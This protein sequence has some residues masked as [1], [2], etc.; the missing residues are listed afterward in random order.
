MNVDNA[1]HDGQAQA[2]T[3]R[4]GAERSVEAVENAA[5]FF[6]G[7]ARAVVADTQYREAVFGGGS[8]FNASALGRIADGVVREVGYHQS[9][10]I[11][12][13][14]EHCRPGIFRNFNVLLGSYWRHVVAHAFDKLSKIDGR[15]WFFG[16]IRIKPGNCEKL[17]HKA[18][19]SINAFVETREAFLLRFGRFCS[20][21]ELHLE[22]QRRERRS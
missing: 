10:S 19:C 17:L 18:S 1:L 14:V 6:G 16:C 4:F 3:G 2:R 7:N 22:L 12:H 21:G 20:L 5:A 15:H 9:N 11:F 8:D 13:A